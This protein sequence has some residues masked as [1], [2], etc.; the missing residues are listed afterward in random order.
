MKRKYDIKIGNF[1]D[2]FSMDQNEWHKVSNNIKM[3]YQ[4][5]KKQNRRNYKN[6]F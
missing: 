5:K 6:N 1:F 3:K 2:S 4:N